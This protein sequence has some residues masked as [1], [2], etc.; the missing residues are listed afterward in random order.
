MRVGCDV[1]M[2]N[3]GLDVFEARGRAEG[4]AND[5]HISARVA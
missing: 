3:L 2:S 4:E 1:E 5:E